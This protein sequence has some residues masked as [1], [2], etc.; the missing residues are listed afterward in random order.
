M[1][2][3]DD[4]RYLLA[5]ARNRSLAGAARSLGVNHSTVFR[6]LNAFEHDLGVRLFERLPDG[7]VPTVEGEEIRRQ[8]EAVEA[9]MHALERTVAGRDYRLSG[10]I[11]MTTAPSLASDYLAGYLAEFRG[12]YPEI[13]VEVAVGDHDF[14]LA[15]READIALRA[16]LTPPEF[17]VGRQV[18]ESRW[19]VYAGKEYLKSHRRPRRMADLGKHP[20]VG[21]DEGM[22]RLPAFAWM[23]RNFPR[24]QFAVRANALV[25]MRALA[26]AGLGLAFLPSDQHQDGLVRLFPLEPE[27]RGALW[28]LTHPDLRHVARIKAFMDFLAAR[29][30]REPRLR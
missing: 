30:A 18:A 15:R 7:Y 10:E 16:T 12:L 9:S 2:A 26:V 4:L 24:A 27:F 23:Q 5:I 8:A 3:W 25:T 21:P 13:Q 19:F 20:L 22:T 29:L 1:F 17:L 6:R 11:R 14:D 28:L